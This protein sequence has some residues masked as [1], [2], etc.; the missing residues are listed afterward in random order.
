MSQVGVWCV[1][2]KM[3]S[4]ASREARATSHRLFFGDDNL[5]SWCA[6]FHVSNHPDSHGSCVS[7]HSDFHGSSVFNHSLSFSSASSRNRVSSCSC[8]SSR[9]R[10]SS[11][12][13]SSSRSRSLLA[14]D[15][16]RA[17]YCTCFGVKDRGVLYVTFI[18]LPFI[19]NIRTARRAIP[20]SFTLRYFR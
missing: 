19:F 20:A 5:V 14:R 3:F 12:S 11:C 9:N 8:S 17:L 4:R 10:V 15:F 2:L 16:T 7:N 18:K 13:R 1:S 6:N